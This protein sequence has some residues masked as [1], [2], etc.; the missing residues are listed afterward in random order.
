MRILFASPY[1]GN[2]G[3]IS[4]WAEHI[5]NHSINSNSECE[6]DVLPMNDVK[7][8]RT[9]IGM[10][11]LQR[12]IYGLQT[13]SRV[14]QSERKILKQ[15]KY[16][17]IHISSSASI[18]L[19]KDILMI[20]VARRQQVKTVIH[21]HFGRIPELANKRNWEWKLLKYVIKLVDYAV[22]MDK[23]S[24]Q[25][26]TNLA[27]SNVV[28]IPNPL[29]PSVEEH[30]NSYGSVNRVKNTLTF[31]GHVVRTKGITE[32]IK[33]C[34][35]LPDIKV[36]IIGPC[37][38]E[39]KL[40]L[41]N[42]VD[43]INHFNFKG[44]LPPKEVIREMLSCSVFVLPTYTEGFPNVILESMACGCPIISTPVGAIPEMLAVDTD[45]PCGLLVEPKNV[46]QLREAI[47]RL[48][49]DDKEALQLSQR[50]SERVREEYS[51]DKVW[52]LIFDLWKS[53]KIKQ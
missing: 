31:V 11:F 7:K 8:G 13:Y 6:L 29:A 51:I 16:D 33:A 18:S 26:L 46:E 25:C 44:T 53:L 30:L 14:I 37:A 50:A 12:I 20:R 49:K 21:F 32:L 27:Y 10:S 34:S 5:V 28:C 22:V 9:S 1:R 3:G 42:I 48:L 35:D 47:M 43:D 23:A 4:Q 45:R 40:E 39:Y 36:N 19:L 2:V 52:N 17:I 15:K 41:M 24:Y 38:D